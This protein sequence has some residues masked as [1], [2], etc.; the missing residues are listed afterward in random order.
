MLRN[1]VLK[2][3]KICK[4]CTLCNFKR[5]NSEM[6]NTTFPPN[7]PSYSNMYRTFKDNS[8]LDCISKF[9]RIRP[10]CLS[11]QQVIDFAK[12]NGTE[13]RSIQ[14]IVNEIPVRIANILSELYMLPPQILSSTSI[15]HV[16]N[17]YK[18]SMADL[19]KFQAYT[20]PVQNDVLTMF[21]DDLFN[22]YERHINVVQTMAEGI[23]E[24][25]ESHLDIFT[26]QVEKKLQ[27]FFD[28]FYLNRIGIRMLISQHLTLFDKSKN[29]QTLTK[30]HV[31]CFDSK[32]EINE[33]V[34]DAAANAIDLCY[35]T[36]AVEPKF[37]IICKKKFCSLIFFVIVINC[38][39]SINF[40]YIP[41]HLYHIIFELMKNACRATVEKYENND[42]DLKNLKVVIAK[43]DEDICISIIDYGSGMCRSVS[44]QMF[45]YMFST[46]PK[47]IG[48][49]EGF[50]A[51]AGYGYGLP[52]SRLYA[53]YFGGDLKV[54]SVDGYG[55]TSTV[56]LKLRPNEA[57]ELL[58]TYNYITRSKYNE[59]NSV[60]GADF[61]ISQPK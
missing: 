17:M 30:H 14:F 2:N 51:L 43:G 50:P 28:R 29:G 46:A 34:L 7:Q 60:D 49:G 25:K 59:K 41:S 11:V 22:I 44:S 19:V 52:L 39:K 35:Q 27:Y 5:F 58:P 26:P 10:A 53:K 23:I 15:S 4:A 33:V 31:G 21:Y 54:H 9:A 45:N 20:I 6:N 61:I 24:L 48:N 12:N 42:I 36:Y 1:F 47:P 3:Y 16:N 32:C 40:V 57:N 56:W 55:T 18:Q 8:M 13:R 37:D 38:D